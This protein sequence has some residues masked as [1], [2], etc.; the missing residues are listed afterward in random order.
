MATTTNQTANKLTARTG[1]T[2]PVEATDFNSTLF[3]VDA[4]EVMD[5][6][7]QC[8]RFITWRYNELDPE[9]IAQESLCKIL[10]KAS[11]FDP[12]KASWRTWVST[13][14]HNKA[15]DMLRARQRRGP[16]PVSLE[17]KNEEF[18][19]SGTP[20]A[21]VGADPADIFEQSEFIAQLQSKAQEAL[22][23]MALA[24]RQHVLEGMAIADGQTVQ[25]TGSSSSR[26]QAYRRLKEI[27]KEL[28]EV[29]MA[30][31]FGD[32][33]NLKIDLNPKILLNLLT[34]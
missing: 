3:S 22:A 14:I 32:V 30:E 6:A 33:N 11:S 28:L 7:H 34:I 26:S 16:V 17:A 23:K 24:P 8:A 25:P 1:T 12:E 2:C 13:I 10:K 21:L 5:Y 18:G 15:M 27:L 4:G 19:D 20:P 31:T 29:E 9:E